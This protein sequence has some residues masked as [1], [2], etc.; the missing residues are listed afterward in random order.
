MPRRPE[1]F[2]SIKD[3][4]KPT[5]KAVLEHLYP[6]HRSRCVSKALCEYAEVVEFSINLRVEHPEVASILLK[7]ERRDGRWSVTHVL[8]DKHDK[9]IRIGKNL[10]GRNLVA[11]ALDDELRDVFGDAESVVIELPPADS[12]QPAD[13]SN[14]RT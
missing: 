8:L 5:V 7:R 3:M 2:E 12:L 6:S 10:L 13:D 4:I 9:L 14:G 1:F 11:K